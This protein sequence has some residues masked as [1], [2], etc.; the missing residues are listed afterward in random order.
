VA[1]LAPLALAAAAGD[2]DRGWRA[3]LAAAAVAA[4]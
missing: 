4:G 1:E 2:T 3:P